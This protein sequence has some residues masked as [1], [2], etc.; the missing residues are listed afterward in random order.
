MQANSECKY[1]VT[2]NTLNAKTVSELFTV[3]DCGASAAGQN[4]NTNYNTNRE[5]LDSQVGTG[6]GGSFSD[7]QVA[8]QVAFEVAFEVAFA[9][10][11]KN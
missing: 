9:K 1:T 8:F 4:H 2:A 6:G 3:T 10:V 11:P 5:C 7:P